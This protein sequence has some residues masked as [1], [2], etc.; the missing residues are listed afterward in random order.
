MVTV[1]AW[2][3]LVFISVV[4]FKAYSPLWKK[5][6]KTLLLSDDEL[7]ALFD[8]DSQISLNELILKIDQEYGITP[9]FTELSAR[10]KCLVNN[11]QVKKTEYEDDGKN[12]N[13]CEEAESYRKKILY[14]IVL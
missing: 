12:D 5:D 4:L 8:K 10:L 9:S 7:L 13:N 1:S 14:S 3:V 2:L 11:G 6:E